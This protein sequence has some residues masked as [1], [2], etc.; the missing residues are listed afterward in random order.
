M[1][2]DFGECNKCGVKL[3][4]IYFIEEEE[5]LYEGTYIKTGRVRKAV[6]YLICPYC[7]DKF[8][9]DDSFD[10]PWISR[11]LTNI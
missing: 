9:V 4:P 2:N 1:A 8:T 7:L 10:G 3:K 6:D 11:R 5:K